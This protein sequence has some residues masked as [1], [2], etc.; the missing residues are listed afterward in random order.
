MALNSV[1]YRKH[2]ESARL[3]RS[4]AE[5]YSEAMAKDILPD[6]ATKADIIGLETQIARL[7][8]E[9]NNNLTNLKTDLKLW[10]VTTQVA[11]LGLALVLAKCLF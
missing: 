6:L 2:L 11:S 4:V 5:T 7:D 8:T 3:E 9:F 1:G 10:M